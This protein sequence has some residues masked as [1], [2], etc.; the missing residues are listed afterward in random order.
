MAEQFV[1]RRAEEQAV[2]DFLDAV[3]RQ[4]AAL[5][6]EGEAGIGKTT[7]WLDAL[8]RAR[9]RGFATL[10]SRAAAAE[11]VLAYTVLA[12]LLGDVDESI[13]ADLPAPQ[14]QALDGALLRQR[15]EAPDIDPRAV[16]AGFVAVIG[17]LAAERPV[18]MAIDDFQWVDTSS[19][20]LVSFAAR[21]LPGGSA[22]V[23]TTRTKEA[24]SRL[25]L[26]SPDGVN[27]IRL[28]PLT[29]G[30]LHQV[31]S[32]RLGRSVARPALLRIH[33]ISGGNPFFALELARELGADGRTSELALPSSLNDLVHSRI[34][35]VGAEDVLLAM[36]S[37]PDP[38]V[39]VVAA[40]TATTPQQVVH[41]LAKAQIQAVV[42]INGNQLR[43]THPLLAHGV[44]RA[45][46]P[47]RRRHMHRRLAALVAQPE[48]R[49]RHLALSDAT[50]QPQTIQA[51]DTAAQIAR[52]RG[53]PA[54][55]AEL[56]EL[57]FGLGADTPE[58]R[59][60]CALC[61]VEAG[62]PTRS[63]IM[64]EK[65]IE[66]CGAGSLRA[67]ALNMLALVRLVNDDFSEATT[68]LER[69]LVDAAD[70]A[71]LQS[72]ILVML[73]YALFN[74]DRLKAAVTRAEEAVA[75]ASQ[76]GDT[77]LLGQALS[78]RVMMRFLNGGGVDDHNLRRA[79]ALEPRETI[80][81]PMRPSAQHALLL[82]WSGRHDEARD[83]L[84]R[85]REM[86]IERGD[87]AALSFLDFNAVLNSIWRGRFDEAAVIAE[88]SV[89]L[90]RQFGGEV[91]LAAALTGRAAVAAYRGDEQQ[92]RSDTT[93]AIAMFEHAN[94][95]RLREWDFTVLGFLE[96][97]LGNYQAAVDAAWPLLS[98][99]DPAI[100]ATEI[101]QASFLPDAV[102]ALIGLGR[103]DDAEPLIDA[104]ERNGRRL[105]RPWMLAVGMRCRAMLQA[106]R[107][108]VTAALGTAELAMTEH[109]RLP[110]PFERARTQLLFGQLHRRHR[111]R[112]A[113]TATLQ[114]ALQTFEQLGAALWAQ[115]A[116]AELAR[117]GLG[118]P[119]SK[120]LTETEERVAELAASGMTNRDIA[121]ALFVSP[122]T[123]EVNLSRI[124]RKLNIR[125]R[126]ELYQAL[127]ALKP[128]SSE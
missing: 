101:V 45:A 79:L 116:K 76:F 117:G 115:R 12:D 35:R 48:L 103:L 98:Q 110:M 126:T 46:S 28:Q 109:Q 14:R 10:S 49:A 105:D 3:P 40:A 42:T 21:R 87:E 2:T 53:G 81:I 93:A 19:A 5:V 68:L 112:D 36:A 1:G 84:L 11:S 64:L 6:I 9:S 41:S 128:E 37:L 30:E 83:R 29:V 119:G 54:A 57:A 92:A 27:R 33:E 15:V 107:G 122:K 60:L 55:A 78:M 91:P 47:A 38:T 39:P 44:Y 34:S 31:L 58:R 97:S 18:V 89:E 106:G 82:D 16:A 70:D 59:I 127:Q 120:T 62:D 88:Q 118:R 75:A 85:L 43:F 121:S 20:N 13:W 50:G 65:T 102:E 77:S 123:V 96:L 7:L 124:Y 8:G 22:L 66:L 90:A 71:A 114:E 51:L 4:S 26:P 73:S 56:L 80:P 17:R 113:A 108:D 95:F 24:A 86:C 63:R 100:N 69:A 94:S 74:G 67:S 25:Q 23:C 111:R 99:L 61:Y 104:L 125:S 72:T 52:Q 32:M